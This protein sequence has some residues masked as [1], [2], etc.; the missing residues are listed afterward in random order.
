MIYNA[1]IKGDDGLYSVRARTDDT[2]RCLVQ[3][4]GVRITEVSDDI[5]FD[6]V[7]ESNIDKIGTVDAQNLEAAVEHCLEWFGRKVSDTVIKR[8][9]TPSLWNNGIRCDRIDAT[10]VFNAQ[11]EPIAY[12]NIQTGKT[13]SVL[14]EFAGL[15]FAKKAFGPSWNVVQVK[16]F[17]EPEPE[18]EPEPEVEPEVEVD[19]VYPDEYAFADEDQE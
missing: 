4:N 9:Y 5:S 7:S 15:W 2:R 19:E 10:K 6:L 18:P 3:V 16:I 1:P 17:D 13:C 11:K 14:L 12:E 8:A